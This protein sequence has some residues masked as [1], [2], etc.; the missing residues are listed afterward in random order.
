MLE[1]HLFKD[2]DGRSWQ[3]SSVDDPAWGPA[4]AYLLDVVS[5]LRY[6]GTLRSEDSTRAICQY[7]HKH[8]YRQI[9]LDEDGRAWEVARTGGSGLTIHEIDFDEARRALLS[10]GPS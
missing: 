2:Q 8:T 10:E 5:A 3:Y 4:Y 1:R 7:I 6:L 9:H